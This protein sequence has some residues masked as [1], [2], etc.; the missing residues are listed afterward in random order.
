MS[1]LVVHYNCVLEGD[2]VFSALFVFSLGF[3]LACFVSLV[4]RGSARF[5][6]GTDQRQRI[7]VTSWS[8]SSKTG[9]PNTL[10]LFL[11]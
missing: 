9:S 4:R 5:Y 10:F 3:L 2:I 7:Q 8:Q 1:G 11:S 6:L